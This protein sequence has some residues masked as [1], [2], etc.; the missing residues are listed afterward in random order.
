LLN[1]AHALFD[2]VKVINME[3]FPFDHRVFE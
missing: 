1:P 2:K 3:K